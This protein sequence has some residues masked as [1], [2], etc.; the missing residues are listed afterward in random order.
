MPFRRRI[1]RQT[2][3]KSGIKHADSFINNVGSG[4]IPTLFVLVETDAGARTELHQEIKGGADTD[5]TCEVGDLIKFIN[6]HIQVAPRNGAN[7]DTGWLEYA[8]VWK[9]EVDAAIAITNMGT[10]TL[11]ETATNLYRNECLWTGF[12]PTS[13]SAAS[14]VELQIKCP[15]AHQYLKIGDQ[16]CLFCYYR[17][18]DSTD[19][20]TD[21]VRLI[22]SCNFK[23]YS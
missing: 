7:L 22:Q 20:Q 15:K 6:V 4:S 9:K 2:R 18:N 3:G 1:R 5:N 8:V 19:V 13:K 16:F 14:G 10:Q 23:A 12:I 17:S 11:G 21:N